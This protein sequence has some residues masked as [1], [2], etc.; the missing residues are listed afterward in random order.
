VS[1]TLL[2][3]I[4][5]LIPNKNTDQPAQIIRHVKTDKGMQEFS[6]P[7]NLVGQ[8]GG[9]WDVRVMSPT[10]PHNLFLVAPYLGVITYKPNAEAIRKNYQ[11]HINK[12]WF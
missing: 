11:E 5:N 7:I 9:Q 1:Q 8:P 12:G 10:G 6:Y 2:G 3:P 4:S